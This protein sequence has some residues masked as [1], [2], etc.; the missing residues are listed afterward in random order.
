[1]EIKNKNNSFV[2]LSD[3]HGNKDIAKKISGYLLERSKNKNE[4]FDFIVLGGDLPN[5]NYFNYKSI[6]KEFLKIN[7]PTIIMPGS[8]EN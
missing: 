8:Y 3:L 5:S 4:D 1:M 2:F 6:V 7:K